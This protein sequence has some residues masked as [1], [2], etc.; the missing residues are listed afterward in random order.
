MKE[1]GGDVQI[2]KQILVKRDTYIDG[3]SANIS[4][5]HYVS[6]VWIGYGTSLEFAYD[7][8]NVTVLYPGIPDFQLDFEKEI[9]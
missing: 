3:Y 7:F 6:Q 4:F 8:W 2:Y 1:G 5:P 9:K